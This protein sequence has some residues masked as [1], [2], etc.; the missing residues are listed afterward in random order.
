MM[1]TY[2]AF[3]PSESEVASYK[4]KLDNSKAEQKNL[5]LIIFQV[6]LDSPNLFLFL[7][8]YCDHHGAYWQAWTRSERCHVGEAGAD[9]EW[10]L[11][12]KCSWAFE[13]GLFEAW[14]G[15]LSRFKCVNYA[16]RPFF[17]LPYDISRL[18]ASCCLLRT[19]NPVFWIL[20][21]PSGLY[22]AEPRVSLIFWTA[23]LQNL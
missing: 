11:V 20:S 7:A 23:T 4:E 9:K 10:N 15:K 3:A 22:E 13:G 18:W 1:D 21:T 8:I 5:F 17:R 19:L 6:K 2:G 14:E 12:D 16:Q